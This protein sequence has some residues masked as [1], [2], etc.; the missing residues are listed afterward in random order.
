M[1]RRA[2][3]MRL[4]VKAAWVRR[5]RALT[6]LLSIVVV[7]TMSTVGLT[8]YSD[9]EAKLNREFRSFGANLVLTAPNA[10][11][12]KKSAAELLARLSANA[13]ADEAYRLAPVAYAI[14]AGPGNSRVVIAGTV[15]SDLQELNSFWASQPVANANGNALL[16]AKA[17]AQ[18][19]PSGAP[20]AISFEG[21]TLEVRPSVIFK[22]GSDD[23]SRIF[24]ELTNFTALTSLRADTVLIYARAKPEVIREKMEM[25]SG[26]FAGAEVKP[27]RA[28]TETQ[29]AVL[30]KTRAV[31]LAAS[32]IVVVLVVL[33]MVAT[34][35]GSVLERRKDFAVMKALGASD[36][37]VNLLFA[38]EASVVAT[39]GGVAGFILGSGIAWWIGH[40][41][42]GAAILPRPLL[43][44]PVVAGSILLALVASSAPLRLLRRIQP[45][46][47]L[48]GE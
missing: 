20:F 27:V 15:L 42:F 48:R 33:C 28:V 10:Q 6:A 11:I 35:T 40:A 26:A 34:L 7:A 24:V 9:L 22:S 21:K 12:D 31:V 4:L 23:D 36:S 41:N 43:L 19:S 5:D 2:L 44:A 8:V 16:G 45:A 46:V 37:T 29:A 13:T 47:I 17:A 25:L 38:G 1:S 30:G 39:A 18:L 3:L 32:A 14:A